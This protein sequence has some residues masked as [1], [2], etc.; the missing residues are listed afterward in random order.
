MWFLPR[1][2]ML[3]GECRDDHCVSLCVYVCPN[4]VLC[5]T[6]MWTLGTAIP[7]LSARNAMRVFHSSFES[8]VLPMLPCNSSF[9]P[10]TVHNTQQAPCLVPLVLCPSYSPLILT[11]THCNQIAVQ[12]PHCEALYSLGDTSLSWC[13]FNPHC[14]SSSL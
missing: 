9:F 8:Y 10:L 5:L 3:S 2:W 13:N 14:Q 11:W 1:L 4:S 7:K 12:L 6:H